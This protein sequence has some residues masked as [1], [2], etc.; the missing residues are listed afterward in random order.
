MFQKE[1]ASFP[2]SA[3]GQEIQYFI[4]RPEGE[5]RAMV[6]LVHGMSEY[7]GRYEPYIGY[8]TGQGFLVY[9]D[10]HLGHKGTAKKPSDRGFFAHEDGWKCLVKDEHKLTGIMKEKYPGLPLFLYGHSMGSFISRAYIAQWPDELAGV[11]L[12]GTSGSNPAMG[13]GK[14]MAGMIKKLQGEKHIS[15]T[16]NLMMFSGYNKKYDHPKSA[17]EWLTRDESVVKAYDEDEW[18]GFP[19]TVSG[20][21]DM[22]CLLEYVS[23][24]KWYEKVPADLP[25]LVA[26]GS[27]DPV[28]GYGKGIEEVRQKLKRKDRKDCTVMLYKDMRHEI[29]NEIGKETVWADMAGWMLERIPK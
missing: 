29:H 8:L 25:M 21:L 28:G 26:S 7:V 23:S 10:N 1:E 17:Y 14:R 5:A 11:I 16:L 4:Y 2:S 15:G 18:C 27:M 3:P 9:G 22:M 13:A 6:Q 24:D 19:F 12:T 20:N